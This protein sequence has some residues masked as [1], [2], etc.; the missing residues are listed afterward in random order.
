[1]PVYTYQA[2]EGKLA[3]QK[4]GGLLVTT[5][6]TESD[7]TGL[8]TVRLLHTTGRRCALPGSLGGELFPGGFATSRLTSGLLGTSHG[9]G[10]KSK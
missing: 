6:F 7:G 8:V 4:L 1:M 3:D 5:N 10:S 9:E 2:L